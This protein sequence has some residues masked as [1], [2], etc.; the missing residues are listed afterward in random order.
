MKSKILILF[1]ALAPVMTQA[2]LM[3]TTNNGAIT[4]TGYNPAAGLNVIIPASTNGYPVTAIG[5]SAF[6]DLFIT[7]VTIGTNI[8]SI[9]DGAFVDCSSLTSVTIPASVT[10]IGYSAFLE[11]TSL[12]NITVDASNLAYSSM[13]GVLFDKAQA[14]LLQ[15]P[16]GLGGSY[17][18]PNSATSIGY[19][20]FFKCTSLT[21]VTIPNSVTAIGGEAFD[22][23]TSLT[24]VTIPN[25]VTSIG[26]YAFA[27]CTSLTSVTIPN[28]VTSI[29]QYAFVDCTSLVSAYF[30]GNA[31]PDDGTAF[32]HDLATV[33]Y[34]SGTTGWG[35]MFGSVRAVLWNPQANTFG[36]TGGHFGFNLTGPANA[37][38]VVEACTNLSHPVWLPVSA[39][40]LSSSGAS[41]FSD[42]QSGGYPMRFYRFRS[43]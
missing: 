16:G 29:G 9:G 2:Q 7:S 20:A 27:A 42:P 1:L 41:A 37:V 34:L 33:Y 35:S 21:S 3:Y 8:T 38:V 14:T 31:P 10:S 26:D 18:I 13:N 25:S 39:N 23:C 15:F 5:A 12:T 6:S 22:N 43:P 40:T 24:S 32:F 17:T 30:Q 28:S 11:C 4:I 19:Y 36:F